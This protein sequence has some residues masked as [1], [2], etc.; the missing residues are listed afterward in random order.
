MKPK[1]HVNIPNQ[2][3][4]GVSHLES[5]AQCHTQAYDQQNL[6]PLARLSSPPAPLMRTSVACGTGAKITTLTKE[7]AHSHYPSDP[8]TLYDSCDSY[9]SASMVSK[10]QSVPLSRRV[11]GRKMARTREQKVATNPSRYPQASLPSVQV[12]DICLRD[13]SLV[14]LCTAISLLQPAP[15][16]SR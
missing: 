11:L 7:V 13:F 2:V 6:L 1:L 10:D 12:H 14:S 3:R 15:T 5:M 8:C 4:C 16:P 9:R